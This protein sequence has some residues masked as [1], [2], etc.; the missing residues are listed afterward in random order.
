[1]PP[2]PGRCTGHGPQV[3][4]VDGQF[5]AGRVQPPRDRAA[6]SQLSRRPNPQTPATT[7][8]LAPAAQGP[9]PGRGGAAGRPRAGL[10]ALSRRPLRRGGLMQAPEAYRA[11]PS[12]KGK[13]RRHLVRLLARRPVHA[14]LE[15]PM[16]SF[17]FD[18]TPASAADL[19][20]RILAANS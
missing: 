13:L 2:W 16:V 12:W 8:A 6:L 15:R 10:A 17:T 4:A 3:R 11:D 20:A 7:L 9:G 18:D 19:G 1:H 5:C 14:R